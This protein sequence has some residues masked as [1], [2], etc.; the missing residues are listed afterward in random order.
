MAGA[1]IGGHGFTV[2]TVFAVYFQ[3]S[4][5]GFSTKHEAFSHPHKHALQANT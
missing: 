4:V 1:G 2:S 5:I 3:L